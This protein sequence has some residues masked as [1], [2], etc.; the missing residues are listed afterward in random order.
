MYLLAIIFIIIF[1]VILFIWMITRLVSYKRQIQDITNQIK[2][3]K[4][5]KSNKIINTGIKDKNIE[6]LAFEINEY[7]TLYKR[8]EQEKVVFENT[9]K[10]GIANMSHDLRT[11]L[12]SIIG[13]LKL[14]KK[15]E[16]SKEEALKILESK[17]NKLNILI[18]Y[19][20]QLA[21]IES[22]DYKL[23][24]TKI[25]LT[26]I[27]RNQILFFYEAFERKGLEPKINILDDPIFI[28]GDKDSVERVIDN[29][30]SNAL[31]YAERDIEITL[32][33]HEGKVVFIISNVC[34]GISEEDVLY[35]FDRFYMADKI[36]KGQGAGLGLAIV[37]SLMEKMKG[38]VTSKLEQNIITITCEWKC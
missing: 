17:A 13:Y 5:R 15:D 38:I 3:F 16:I 18:D 14:L 12:T 30:I 25:N 31:K 28:M 33:E 34:K 4:E 32:K 23:D 35:M 8:H 37:K 27:V 10:Q 36:R 21:S 9:L 24:L 6:A 2:E 1:I 7:L 29:L 26:N 22:E 11:P 19:F 20:F